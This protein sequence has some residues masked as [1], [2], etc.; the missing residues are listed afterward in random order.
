MRRLWIGAIWLFGHAAL[1]TAGVSLT[2]LYHL[3][4]CMQ[5]IEIHVIMGVFWLYRWR[6]KI[7]ILFFFLSA[8]APGLQ[9]L[10]T[11]SHRVK[12]TYR[13][14]FRYISFENFCRVDQRFQ[15][16]CCSKAYGFALDMP[17]IAGIRGIYVL[18]AALEQEWIWRPA[19][20]AF[21]TKQ[22]YVFQ[23][24]SKLYTTRSS[25]HQMV[26]LIAKA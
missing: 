5:M 19:E 14:W 23:M 8:L 3:W 20:D 18:Y 6:P 12:K 7:L 1:P 4:Y 17:E 15:K 9:E 13:R 26:R 22:P 2:E 16:A 21:W 11:P 10:V 25:C 24:R